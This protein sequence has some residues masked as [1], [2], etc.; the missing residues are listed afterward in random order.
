VKVLV[1]GGRNFSNAPRLYSALNAFH[2][3]HKVS[4]VIAGG[5]RG[6][7]TLAA[8]W[9]TTSG[10]HV[11]VVTALWGEHGKSAGPKRNRAMLLLAP[12]AV[13]AFAGGPGTADM[14]AAA[15]AAGINVWE[16]E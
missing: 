7:D 10:I 3:K 2:A 1:C 5:A 14:V 6:A 16:V 15:K 9:A 11:A 13:I 12:D 4:L 8:E